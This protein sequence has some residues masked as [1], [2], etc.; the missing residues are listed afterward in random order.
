MKSAGHD[1]FGGL[2][3]HKSRV[4]ARFVWV[5]G[6]CYGV[7][8]HAELSC[9][10]TIVMSHNA[11]PSETA[12]TGIRRGKHWSDFSW[13]EVN[14]IARYRGQPSR[15]RTSNIVEDPQRTGRNDAGRIGRQVRPEYSY[16]FRP[17]TRPN[18]DAATPVDRLAGQGTGSRREFARPIPAGRTE[19]FDGPVPGVCHAL[20]VGRGDARRIGV[21]EREDNRRGRSPSTNGRPAQ[22][23]QAPVGAWHG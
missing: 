5:P 4:R 12:V 21:T 3:S 7:T 15:G 16:D 9:F 10:R 1:R 22:P 19:S 2:T 20:A 8:C 18:D 11:G 23:C 6:V 14:V 13:G 17:G